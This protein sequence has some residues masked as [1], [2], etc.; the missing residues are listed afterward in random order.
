MARLAKEAAI[1]RQTVGPRGLLAISANLVCRYPKHV[2]LNHESLRHPLFVRLRTSDAEV[3]EDIFLVKAY[4]YPTSVPPRT[5][6]DVGANCGMTSVYYANRYPRA[7]VVSVEP[8]NSNYA[9]L[10]R[11]TRA[12]PNVIPIHAALWNEDG[13]VELFPGWPRFR[14]WGKWGFRVRQG[15]GCRALTLPTL[16]REVGFKNVDILKIDVEGAEREIFSNCDWMGK[17]KLLAIELHDRN[18]PGCTQAVE[19]VTSQ[20]HKTE[21]GFVTF[22]S[23]CA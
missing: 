17:V 4:D 12:Y 19:A 7:T 5:I 14:K 1:Y 11:N 22:Y 16:M 2:S 20:Y 6:V 21:R 15:S 3:Y 9:A 8:E 18:W 23:R 13:E 10:V